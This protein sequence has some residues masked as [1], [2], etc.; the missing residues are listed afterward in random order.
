M[1]SRNIM[2]YSTRSTWLGLTFIMLILTVSTFAVL[3]QQ[4]RRLLDNARNNASDDIRFIKLLLTEALQQQNFEHL[5]AL[6]HSWGQMISYTQELQVTAANGFVLGHFQRDQEAARPYTLQASIRYAYNG[7]ATVSFTKDLG[8]IDA[9]I[10]R[11]R[12]QLFPGLLLI[13][14]VFWRM[15]WLGLQ[16]KYKAIALDQTNRRLRETADQLETTRAYLRNVFDS[17]PS[18][19]IGV[20]AKGRVSMWNMGAEKLFGLTPAKVIGKSFSKAIPAYASLMPK[21]MDAINTGTPTLI[22]RHVSH[23]VG[24]PRFSEIMIYPLHAVGTRGAVVRI[25]DITQRIQIEQMMVQSEKMLTVGGLAAGM[26]HE[27]NNPLSGIL[28]STQNIL[29]RVSPELAENL[30]VAKQL[31]LDLET[32]NAFLDRRGVLGFLEGIREAAQRAGRIVSDMLAFSR[33]STSEFTQVSINELLDTVVRIASTDYDL[34]KTYDF[35]KIKIIKDYDPTLPMVLCDRVEIEQVLLN[36]IKNATY[37]MAE[38]DSTKDQFIYLRS[39]REAETIRIEIEDTGPGMDEQTKRR[40]FEPFFTTKPIGV[41]T[42][43]GLSVSY[44]I[45]SEQHKGTIS[46]DST[47]NRGARFIIRLPVA[48]TSQRDDHTYID[49]R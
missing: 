14:L 4:E 47:P 31:G 17:M 22:E 46:V 35:K 28:Q 8:S 13:G 40:V 9:S 7:L 42:G 39:A 23:E 15:S 26:A 21:L 25:D 41:G 2:K 3:E 24:K 36:L 19:L 44:Y 16:R 45:I 20:D 27:I 11:L 37:A 33:R 10:N 30:A 38:A 43:L 5:N 6:V 29:R 34:K 18:T 12:W 1:K 48:P 49:R 32:M